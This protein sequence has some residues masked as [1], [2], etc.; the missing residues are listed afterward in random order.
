M[1]E[2]PLFYY[3]LFARIIPGGFLLGFIALAWP[4]LFYPMWVG[5]DALRAVMIPIAALGIAYFLGDA[6]EAVMRP[7]SDLVV[8][9]GFHRAAE[10]QRPVLCGSVPDFEVEAQRTG[11]KPSR[12]EDRYRIESWQWLMLRTSTDSP[13]AF[14]HAHRFQ[15][16]SKMFLHAAIPAATLAAALAYG[17]FLKQS[18]W[19][20]FTVAFVVWVSA[21]VV[22][23]FATRGSETR[24]WIQ[25]IATADLLGFTQKARPA[26]TVQATTVSVSA[27]PSLK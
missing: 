13:N 3:D 18:F 14:A 10:R 6:I 1:K 5:P 21:F 9:R 26:V 16:S 12:I 22:A 23:F 19:V 17:S 8:R 20:R 15:C 4:R 2:I 24:R 27:P 11:E 25:V 7:L